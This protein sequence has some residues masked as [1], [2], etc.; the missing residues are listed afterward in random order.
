MGHPVYVL[1]ASVR[2][3]R[4]LDNSDRA[5]DLFLSSTIVTRIANVCAA[6]EYEL[7][8]AFHSL[9]FMTR[10]FFRNLNI[11]RTRLRL[12]RSDIT[13]RIIACVATIIEDRSGQSFNRD[14]DAKLRAI[15][16]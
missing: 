3:K 4:S 6:S 9:F 13:R 5:F 15:C 11:K 10:A 2:N 16:M 7:K 8:I 1:L 12:S 14:T